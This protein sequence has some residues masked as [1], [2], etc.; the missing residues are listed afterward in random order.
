MRGHYV[1]GHFRGQGLTRRHYKDPFGFL[2]PPIMLIIVLG[3]IGWLLKTLWMLILPIA[4]IFT[5]FYILIRVR[6]KRKLLQAFGGYYTTR[7]ACPNCH[8]MNDFKYETGK[9]AS[10]ITRLCSKCGMRYG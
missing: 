4:L 6:R 2:L 8:R 5:T 10:G 3:F 7:K 1:R 9:P